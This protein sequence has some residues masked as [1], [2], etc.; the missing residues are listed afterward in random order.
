MNHFLDVNTTILGETVPTPA[1]QE[2]L[3]TN[4]FSGTGSLGAQASTCLAEHGYY[5]TFTLVDFYDVG[6]GSVFS[7]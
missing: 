2:L 6:D 5:P 3:T 4:A 7:A 1:T